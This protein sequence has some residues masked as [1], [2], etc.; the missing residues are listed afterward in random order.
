MP[1]SFAVPPVSYFVIKPTRI[2][3]AKKALA[4]NFAI[5]RIFLVFFE[6][7]PRSVSLRGDERP[8]LRPAQL[9]SCEYGLGR[10]LW[11]GVR[12]FTSNCLLF[13]GKVQ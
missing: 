13:P 11:R 1:R 7:S 4:K 2:T 8:E 9:A 3:S 6:F 12:P 10:M 5:A